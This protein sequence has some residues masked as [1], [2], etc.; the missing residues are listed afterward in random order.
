MAKGVRGD[1]ECRRV[2]TS[3]GSPLVSNLTL[4]EEQ[5][6]LHLYNIDHTPHPCTHHMQAPS[7]E[8]TVKVCRRG[9]VEGGWVTSLGKKSTTKSTVNK[10]HTSR[11]PPTTTTLLFSSTLPHPILLTQHG[12]I[13]RQGTLLGADSPLHSARLRVQV[14]LGSHRRVQA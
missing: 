2:E 4:L 5:Y 3:K 11:A 9:V 10:H 13:P 7:R 6:T 1:G 8:Y 12:S 14:R